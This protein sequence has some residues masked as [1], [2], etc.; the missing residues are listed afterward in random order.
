MSYSIARAWGQT[1]FILG[2]QLHPV[3]VSEV[4]SY[5]ERVIRSNEKALVLNLNI[6]CVNLAVRSPW[7]AEFINQAQMVFCDGDGV[8]MG[9]KLLNFNPPPKI[10]YADWMWQLAA[11]CE[12]KQ[13]SLYFLGGSPG[14]AEKAGRRLVQKFPSLKL[15]GMGHGFFKKEGPESESVVAEINRLK[16]DIL[17]VGF[18][19]PA[20]E[21]WLR[22]NWQSLDVHIFLTGGAVFD[23]LSGNLKRAP[24]W[25]LRWHLEWFFRLLQQPRR[26]FKRYIIGNP[27]FLFRVLRVKWQ[28]RTKK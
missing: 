21:E 1:Y 24:E 10:T 20:Q 8:R 15:A 14:V 2:L 9:L 11:F 16:P 6:H 5:V 12:K 18:G 25:M 26:L 17:V 3:G 23:Y 13:F 27:E 22:K 19:M 28:K 4:H 7:L